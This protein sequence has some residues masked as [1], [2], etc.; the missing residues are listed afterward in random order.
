M[1]GTA[2]AVFYA[3][4]GLT[5]SHF[6]ARAHLVVAR[7]ILDSLTPGWQQIGAVWLPLP[8]VLN[9]I[10]VQVD[11][12]Y[13]SGASGVALSVASTG[14]T[15]WA[16]ARVILISTGSIAGGA[17]GAALFITNPNLLYIQSTP[18]TEP[19]L[20]ATAFLTLAL[21]AA[22]I[23]RG[24]GEWPTAPGLALS[25]MC[26]TRYEGWIIGAA[27]IGLTT[28]ILLR[29]G[30]PPSRALR[31]S[32][33]LATLPIIAIV[34]FTLNSRW[35]I[36]Y[37]FI[38]RDFFVPENAA[39]GHPWLAWDQVR[40]SVH[41]L[42]NSWLVRCGYIGAAL[43]AVALFASR[44]RATLALLFSIVAAGALPWYAYLQ[45]HPVRIRYG[46]T[47]VAA[48]AA[49]GGA[50]VALLWRPVRWIG[51]ALVVI[52]V[53]WQTSP[54]DRQAVLVI[55][56]QRDAPNIEGR[57][58]ITRYLLEHYKGDGPIMISMGSL[59]HYMQELGRAGFPIHS[60][61]HEGNG[62]AWRYAVLG[63]KGYVNWVVIEESAEG[64]DALYR[65][66]KRNPGYLEGF[67]RVAEG[68]GAALYRSSRVQEK[69][70]RR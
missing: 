28:C 15:A 22:W 32:I 42:S 36:G 8:H 65:A 2:A 51:A 70:D 13:R 1:A 40:E 48:S 64:G 7:R 41:K 20:F 23:D 25:A 9:M 39:L 59:A 6:D 52:L 19:L 24:I 34:L 63:P 17:A 21:L 53:T 43:V 26:M 50:G 61:L 18:M 69:S 38:P 62:E 56:S 67:E 14:L 30:E 54:V 12:W 45:G 55:E 47:L 3:Q 5:L 49:L 58:A 37:W 27:A 35:T 57:R 46:L 44:R 68:G 33:Q 16:I 10:P 31:A 29:R 60:I 11:A 4:S 66:W